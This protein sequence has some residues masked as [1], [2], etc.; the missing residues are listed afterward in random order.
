[1]RRKYN[2][3]I[4][5][6]IMYLIVLFVIILLYLIV[7][8]RAIDAQIKHYPDWLD[9]SL[10]PV[11][12]KKANVAFIYKMGEVLYVRGKYNDWSTIENYLDSLIIKIKATNVQFDAIVGIKSGGAIL[13]KYIADRL[14]LPYYYVKLSDKDYHCKKKTIHIFDYLYKLVIG[15][16]KEYIICEPIEA[17]LTNQTILLFDEIITSGNTLLNTI[18]Y[19]LENK[20]VNKVVPAAL[21]ALKETYEDYKPLH[22]QSGYPTAIWP[23]GYDN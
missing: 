18:K 4:N 9:K 6:N 10:T 14:D 22:I 16:K 13:T 5:P 12:E 17:D 7:R 23:W 1:M 15:K 21:V 8:V 19:L 2:K 3:K 20:G 11:L